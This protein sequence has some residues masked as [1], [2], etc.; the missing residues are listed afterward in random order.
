MLLVFMIVV[1][2]IS[3]HFRIEHRIWS[4][5]L[6]EDERKLRGLRS[7]RL[8]F[9][10]NEILTVLEKRSCLLAHVLRAGLTSL[11]PA[12]CVPSSWIP[13]Q[14]VSGPRAEAVYGFADSIE[15]SDYRA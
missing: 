9:S 10:H 1:S 15:D 2:K 7:Q 12:H 5:S 11:H 6:P 4:S 3:K 13:A 14:M 8:T